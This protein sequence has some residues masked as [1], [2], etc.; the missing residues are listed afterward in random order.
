MKNEMATVRDI[1]VVLRSTSH[2]P[3][4]QSCP[5]L[6][7]GVPRDGLE[8]VPSWVSPFDWWSEAAHHGD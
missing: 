6:C 7:S 5:T 8:S 4:Y 2:G 3:A 1:N